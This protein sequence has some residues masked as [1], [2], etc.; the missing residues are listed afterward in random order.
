MKFLVLQELPGDMYKKIA[1]FGHISE[2]NQS[3]VRCVVQ[4]HKVALV[5]ESIEAFQ[6]QKPVGPVKK[7]A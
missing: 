3:A 2:A 4:T 7:R 6:M 1:E 5:V